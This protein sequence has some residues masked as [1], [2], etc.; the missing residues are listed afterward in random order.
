MHI[1]EAIIDRRKSA[2][3]GNVLVDLDLAV[4]IIFDETRELGSS[5]N[6]TEGG[7]SPC[8][9]SDQ[10]ERASGNL[11]PCSGDANDG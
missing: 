7:S 6:T 3:V 8:P 11:H 2:L 4:Q 10:L 5:F 1:V 9:S